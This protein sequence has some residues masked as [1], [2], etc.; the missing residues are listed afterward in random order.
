MEVVCLACPLATYM[1]FHPNVSEVH[2]RTVASRRSRMGIPT[3]SQP[4]LLSVWVYGYAPYQRTLQYQ[5]KLQ[6]QSWKMLH[7]VALVG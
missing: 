3:S 6:Y 2:S 7:G 5:R 4:R 1:A